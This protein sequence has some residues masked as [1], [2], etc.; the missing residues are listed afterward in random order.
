MSVK[1]KECSVHQR[2]VKIK[3]NF[4]T[5]RKKGNFFYMSRKGKALYINGKLKYRR[6]QISSYPRAMLIEKKKL[7][8]I[9]YFSSVCIKVQRGQRAKKIYHLWTMSRI[10]KEIK[11]SSI[12]MYIKLEGG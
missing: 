3:G 12:S 7:K 10:R 1:N 9:K 8:I 2:E 11:I 4:Y 5:L 6:K